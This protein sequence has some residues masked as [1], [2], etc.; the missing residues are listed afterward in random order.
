MPLASALFMLLI[1]RERGVSRTH[2]RKDSRP[3]AMVGLSGV[4]V[5]YQGTVRPAA[6]R[7]SYE[8]Y[9]TLAASKEFA[10]LKT[11]LEKRDRTTAGFSVP[12]DQVP[13]LLATRTA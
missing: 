8:N 1:T 6:R 9:I 10:D 4:N 5:W 11:P 2:T 13:L 3:T 12:I 7:V